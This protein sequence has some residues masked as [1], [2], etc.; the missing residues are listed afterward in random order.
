MS[1]KCHRLMLVTAVVL[2]AASAA[3]GDDLPLAPDPAVRVTLIPDSASIPVGVTMR[4]DVQIIGGTASSPQRV[5]G[6]STSDATRA[7]AVVQESAQACD[8][9]AIAPGKLQVIVQVS[10][11]VRDS[12]VALVVAR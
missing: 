5:T 1:R 7:T 3:C 2:C 11:G 12:A 9:L 8:V 4:Y 6:C 10:A